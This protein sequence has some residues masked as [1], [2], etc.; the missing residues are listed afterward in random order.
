MYSDFKK[1]GIIHKIIQKKVKD[2]FNNFKTAL[3]ISE[4]IEYNIKCLTKY[5]SNNPLKAGIA[6]PTGICIND[7][8]AHFT[9]SIEN[10]PIIKNDDLIKI[11]F[12]VHING[13]ISDGAFSICKSGKYNDLINISVGATELAIKNSGVDVIL[14]DLG[15]IIQEYI[16]SKEIEI[17][18]KVIN[19][20][21]IYDLSGH[22]IAPYIIHLNKAVPNIKIN[23]NERM[24]EGEIFAIET[25]PTTGNGI[26]INDIICN[27]YMIE[28]KYKNKINNILKK[29]K[30]IRE[31][32]NNRSTLAF[33]PRW[34]NFNIPESSFITKYPVLKTIDSGIVPCMKKL[35]YKRKI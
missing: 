3:D 14:G 9:P 1:A 27:H 18:G 19:I 34:F 29:N 32:Y 11:D 30:K 13:C 25:F 15:G 23:Y 6:F 21:S 33:C 10:N 24:N 8:A 7:V 5:D 12:G 22:N 31:I 20:K 16:E 4:F 26:I 2:N 35:F 17:D 28:Y